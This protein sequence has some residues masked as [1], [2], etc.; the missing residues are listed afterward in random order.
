MLKKTFFFKL[1]AWSPGYKQ[2]VGLTKHA[3]S[4]VVMITKFSSDMSENSMHIRAN[5]T[6][7]IQRVWARLVGWSRRSFGCTM[8]DARSKGMRV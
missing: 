8:R 6:N 3:N 5:P 2:C 4:L 7:A 1:G